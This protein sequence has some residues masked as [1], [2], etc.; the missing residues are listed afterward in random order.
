M[1]APASS[2]DDEVARWV[3]ERKGRGMG[4]AVGGAV[5]KRGEDDVW[6]PFWVVW[7]KEK[8]KG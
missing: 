4:A 2:D 6:V 5:G 7:M 3:R 8:N 1:P